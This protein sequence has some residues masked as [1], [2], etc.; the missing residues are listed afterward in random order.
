MKSLL[1]ALMVMATAL[2]ANALSFNWGTGATRAQFPTGT[3]VTDGSVTAYLVYLGN[4]AAAPYAINDYGL[5]NPLMDTGASTSTGL[6]STRGRIRETFDTLA[7]GASIGGGSDTFGNG[8]TFGMLLTHVDGGV[9]WYNLAANTYTV[10]G[11]ADDGSVLD[12]AVFTF[13]FAQNAQGDPLTVGGG[14]ATPVPEPG[15]AA[16]ALAGLAMLIRRRK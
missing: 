4:S 1:T 14:W 7:Y 3:F 8:S 15:T 13:S 2:S 6:A 12:V 10:A 11:A 16:L 9:T 5:D